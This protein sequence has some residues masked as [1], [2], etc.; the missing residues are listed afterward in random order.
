MVIPPALGEIVFN[1][2]IHNERITNG[3][4]PL[5]SAQGRMRVTAQAKK[6]SKIEAPGP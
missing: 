2:I 3:F 4:E 1:S 6:N 5:R